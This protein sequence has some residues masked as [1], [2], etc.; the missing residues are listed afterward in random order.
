[1]G[2][3][4]FFYNTNYEICNKFNNLI[5]NPIH[6]QY[7]TYNIHLIKFYVYIFLCCR[8]TDWLSAKPKA[9]RERL[10][11]VAMKMVDT[12]RD[13]G[14]KVEEEIQRR[15]LVKKIDRQNVCIIR[16]WH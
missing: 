3:T 13:W 10:I 15:Q 11:G 16:L 12:D 6:Q 9:E 1:M 5:S 4:L 2:R 14:L 7:N 8:T